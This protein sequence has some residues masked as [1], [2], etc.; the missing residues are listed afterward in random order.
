MRDNRDP[1]DPRDDDNSDRSGDGTLFVSLLLA[2]VV[3]VIV[4]VSV[5]GIFVSR[6]PVPPTAAMC[7]ES[8]WGFLKLECPTN[9]IMGVCFGFPGCG[10]TPHVCGQDK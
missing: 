1:D 7:T 4:V 8:C 6:N 10:G 5:A 3:G 9:R 2:I